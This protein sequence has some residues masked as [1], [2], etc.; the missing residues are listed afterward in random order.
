MKNVRFAA[1]RRLPLRFQQRA[2][3]DPTQPTNPTNP[4]ETNP[5]TGD[6]SIMWLWFALLLVSGTCIAGI[7]VYHKEEKLNKALSCALHI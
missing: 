7:T 1:T 5:D 4:G 3:T 2:T 6:S